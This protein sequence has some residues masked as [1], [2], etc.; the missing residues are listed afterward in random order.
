[1]D[2]VLLLGIVL[3]MSS[4][5]LVGA[6]CGFTIANGKKEELEMENTEDTDTK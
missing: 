5:F 3:L 2:T 4:M 1:M 6:F